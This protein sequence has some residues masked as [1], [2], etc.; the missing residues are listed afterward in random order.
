LFRVSDFGFRFSALLLFCLLPLASLADS[1]DIEGAT[2]AR[3]LTSQRPN[4][5]VT[6]LATLRIRQRGQPLRTL[7][8]RVIIQ[9]GSPTWQ[10]TYEAGSGT[11]LTVLIIH[12]G[13]AT[14]RGYTLIQPG[15]DGPRT[16]QLTGNATMIPFAGS[17]FC[18]ADLGLEFLHW[19]GQRIVGREM[20]RSRGCLILESTNPNPAPGAYVRVRSWIDS[21]NRGIV[22]AEAYDANNKLLKVF[23]P[24]DPTKVE[25]RW[26]IEELELR[27][28]QDKSQ[29]VIKF[30]FTPAAA[31]PAK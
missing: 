25:G 7:P 21:E 11:N 14:T 29:T 23:T 22:I 5:S 9:D 24:N 20:R 1:A 8:L 4:A 3:E 18:V 19:P 6:N 2:L 13:D 26:E 28:V 15:P 27:N 31:S 12:H 17:D 16:N 30:D 10:G